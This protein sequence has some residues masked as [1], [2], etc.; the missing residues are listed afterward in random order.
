MSKQHAWVI[1]ADRKSLEH[2]AKIGVFGLKSPGELKKVKAGDMLIAYVSKEKIFGGIGKVTKDYYPD[3]K[4][5]F[6]W[7]LYPDRIGIDLHLVPPDKAVN[8]WD[9]IDELSFIPKEGQA[10]W[11]VY[12]RSGFREITSKDF[13]KISTHLKIQAKH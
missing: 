5:I 7:G 8:I 11:A 6:P 1:S 9:V 2:C 10:Y 3:D 4:E 13:E 12:F